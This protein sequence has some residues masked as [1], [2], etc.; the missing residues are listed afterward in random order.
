[1]K[2]IFIICLSLFSFSVFGLPF[3]V[4]DDKEVSFDVIRKKKNIGSLISKF[5]EN[6]DSVVIHSVLKINVKVLF[7]PAYNFFQ[8]TKETWVN[9]EFVSIDGF[10]DFEDDREYKIIG[11]DKDNF[12]ITSGMDGKLNLNKNIVPLNYWNLEMLKEK[13][14]FDT[15]KGIVRTIKVNQLEDEKIKINNLEILANKYL[16]NASKH[17]KDKG[18]FPE[19]TLWYFEKEL[20][21]MEF[22]N[23]NDKK[24]IITIIRNDWG[25]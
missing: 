24:N 20:I 1:M 9:G 7:F 3:P 6:E 25:L 13:E 21:K 8:E 2:Y 12:F 22:K 10:T 16:F 23:P 17:P 5:E 19:Y 18:P 11:S 15:Q 14:V 4:P